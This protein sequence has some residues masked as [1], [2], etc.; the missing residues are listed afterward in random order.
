[1]S[2]WLVTGASGLLGH[3]V[4]NHLV[5]QG[6][7]VVALH[8][9]H[10]V[11]VEGAQ[12]VSM[13]LLDEE[14]LLAVVRQ[15]KPDFIF[16]T[17][18]L[19]NVDECQK[20]PED[21]HR[22]NAHIPQSLAR[23]ARETGSKLIHVTTDQLWTGSKPNVAEEEATDPVNVYGETKAL[24]EKLVL[25]QAPDAII[26]RT[27]FF[28]EGRPWR[29]SFSDWLMHELTH[30]KEIQGFDDIFY[31]PIALDYFLPCAFELAI[32][33][34]R[35]IFHLAGSERVSKYQ[36]IE[37]FCSIFGLD[38]ALVKKSACH[39]ANLSAPRPKD[40]SLS[41]K[42]IETVLGR[43]MPSVE[44]SILTLKNS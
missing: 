26:L 40:M 19:A 35:G 44:E 32:K 24:S 4:C 2:K 8:N 38:L 29:K 11:E 9:R 39:E 18:A 36:F 31:T 33:G 12:A 10:P 25:E 7:N 1:M 30:K 14:K 43:P 42:K 5:A 13:D 6:D 28:G 22:Y 16:H 37:K 21:A 20:H 23:I 17:A 15:E 34:E 3:H 41:V 27:N